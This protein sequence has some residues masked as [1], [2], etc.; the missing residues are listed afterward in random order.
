[1][2]FQKKEIVAKVTKLLDVE[3]KMTKECQTQTRNLADSD[4]ENEH[5]FRE[6]DEPILYKKELQRGN[7]LYY[8]NIKYYQQS[9]L[10]YYQDKLSFIQDTMLRLKDDK[11]QKKKKKSGTPVQT[12][13][14]D[15]VKQI[16]KQ[17]SAKESKKIE[18]ANKAQEKQLLANYPPK[19]QDIE[20]LKGLCRSLNTLQVQ[21]NKYNQKL[22]N[23]EI[24]LKDLKSQKLQKNKIFTKVQQMQQIKQKLIEDTSRIKASP[25]YLGQEGIDDIK[26]LKVQNEKLT[27]T[28]Q[29][30]KDA[31]MDMLQFF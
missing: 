8:V 20:K 7:C 29:K 11:N 12:E 23:I 31:C 25:E 24:R 26:K 16:E 19:I 4:G 21:D 30:R 13:N 28:V 14:T 3:E 1:M 17:P 22:H 18:Q 6:I 2:G 15:K 10:T 9:A 5:I 27:R